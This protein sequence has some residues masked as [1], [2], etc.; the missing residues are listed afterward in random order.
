MVYQKSSQIDPQ[1]G[2][3]GVENFG[4]WVYCKSRVGNLCPGGTGRPRKAAFLL[5]KAVSPEELSRLTDQFLARGGKIT[6]CPTGQT[7]SVACQRFFIFTELT[8]PN[9]PKKLGTTHAPAN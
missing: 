1:P 3:G 9:A 2:M 6:K 8:A 4:A 7:T 5:E